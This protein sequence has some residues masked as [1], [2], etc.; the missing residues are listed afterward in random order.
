VLGL[1]WAAV[2]AERFN[3][4]IGWRSITKSKLV[5]GGEL[6]EWR[7]LNFEDVRALGQVVD[8]N[9]GTAH[10]AVRQ[11][12]DSAVYQLTPTMKLESEEHRELVKLL[13]QMHAFSV[14]PVPELDQRAPPRAIGHSRASDRGRSV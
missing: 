5:L 4:N 9:R 14:V 6:F 13:V 10:L 7:W 8:P 11:R 1:I 12:A 3:I 2:T